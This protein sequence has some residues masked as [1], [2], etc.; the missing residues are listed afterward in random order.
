[1]G[2]SFYRDI[3]TYQSSLSDGLHTNPMAHSVTAI[4]SRPLFPDN[5]EL[6]DSIVQTPV[7]KMH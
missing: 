5:V 3:L 7:L 2:D 6:T 4:P 1:M